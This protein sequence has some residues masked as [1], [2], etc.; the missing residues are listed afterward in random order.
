MVFKL[1]YKSST[2]KIISTIKIEEM[3]FNNLHTINLCSGPLL[4][5]GEEG[6]IIMMIRFNK[7]TIVLT[8]LEI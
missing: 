2:Q 8:N 1:G 4:G 5:R 6:G 3:I 7:S